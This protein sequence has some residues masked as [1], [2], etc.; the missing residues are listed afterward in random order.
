M[1]HGFDRLQRILLTMSVGEEISPAGAAE[2]TGLSEEVCR[3]VLA[4]LER[5][6]LMTH[7]PG[8]RFTRC[9]LN[10]TNV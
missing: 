9:P 6:G 8:D 7:G 2:Q 5:A 3:A 10:L 1:N 4:G